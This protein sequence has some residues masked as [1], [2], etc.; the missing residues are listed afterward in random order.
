HRASVT[1]LGRLAAQC[2][3]RRPPPLVVPLAPVKLAAEA[4]VRLAGPRRAGRLLLTPESLHALATDPVVDCSKAIA[5]L[6]YR[7]RPL[8]ETVADL[9][10][11]FVAEGRLTPRRG[12]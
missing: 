7:P 3:G 4:A 2:R 8:T 5:E 6:G 12:R 1:E 10:A 9:H 11:A